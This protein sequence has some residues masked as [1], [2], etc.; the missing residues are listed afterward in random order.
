MKQY[1]TPEFKTIYF[2]VKNKIMDTPYDKDYD[3][4]DNPWKDLL[5][6]PTSEVE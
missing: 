6:D 1:Q 3:Y 4:N 2:D 5:A